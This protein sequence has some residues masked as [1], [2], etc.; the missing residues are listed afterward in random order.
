MT[1]GWV[2]FRRGTYQMLNA[3]QQ[4]GHLLTNLLGATQ[5]RRRNVHN[6][7]M[8]GVFYM[9]GTCTLLRQTIKFYI[10]FKSDIKISVPKLMSKSCPKVSSCWCECRSQWN[11]YSKEISIILKKSIIVS[12]SNASIMTFV[13][14]IHGRDMACVKSL[15]LL[16]SI[17]LIQL[18]HS[19]FLCG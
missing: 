11:L 10:V 3:A 1:L 7:K 4:C 19:F 5:E 18:R 9:K 12:S 8:D 17:T 6:G 2:G 15:L 14:L 16:S 13:D